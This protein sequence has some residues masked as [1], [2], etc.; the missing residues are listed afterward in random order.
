M[1]GKLKIL[2]LVVGVCASIASLAQTVPALENRYLTF[3]QN[4]EWLESIVS[5]D[6]QAQWKA[7]TRRCFLKENANVPT[8]STTYSPTIVINGVLFDVPTNVKDSDRERIVSLL[9]ADSLEQVTLI[10]KLSDGLIFCKPFAG[11][12]LLAVRKPTEK[13]LFKLKL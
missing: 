3:S 2:I 12:I 5:L 4:K 1:H 7:I 8:D 10:G 6:Q 13:K 11:V 9:S